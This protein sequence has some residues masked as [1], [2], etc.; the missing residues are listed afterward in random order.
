MLNH[1][2]KFILV[3]I[4]VC[5]T[6]MMSACVT[7]PPKRLSEKFGFAVET[8]KAQQTANPDASSNTKAAV[9]VDGI[10]GD[11]MFDNYRNSFITRPAPSEGIL[12]IGTSGG[13]TGGGGTSGR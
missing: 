1:N 7:S 10:A 2:M 3:F 6:I 4:I 5:L 8:A 11:A 12:N 13:S 9:G